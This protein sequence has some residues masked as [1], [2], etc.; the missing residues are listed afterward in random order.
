[1]A[2]IVAMLLTSKDQ[3][4]MNGLPMKA[5]F[6]ELFLS[7]QTMG[8]VQAAK[9]AFLLKGLFRGPKIQIYLL[10]LSCKK[11]NYFLHFCPIIF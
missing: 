6:S 11:K 7:I 8:A 10:G 3:K 5:Y 1:M 9:K 2:L 4:I